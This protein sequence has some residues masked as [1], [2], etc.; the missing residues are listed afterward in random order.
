MR[1]WASGGL[2][3]PWIEPWNYLYLC[4]AECHCFQLHSLL[5]QAQA[6][7]FYRYR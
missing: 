2:R 4:A 3:M 6:P 5:A 1:H 7:F